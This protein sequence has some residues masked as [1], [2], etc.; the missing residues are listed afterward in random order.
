MSGVYMTSKN[1]EVYKQC[2]Q[3]I[4]GKLSIKELSLLTGKSYRQTQ[5]II[6]KV[7]QKGMLGVKHGNFGKVPKNKTSALVAE[8]IRS[9]LKKDY[10]DFNLTHFREM[11]FE[12]EGIKIGKILY[13]ELRSCMA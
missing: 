2:Q 12:K 9:L 5:R 1:E 7:R 6:E 10:Y 3:T 13:I 11:L 8:D 4:E